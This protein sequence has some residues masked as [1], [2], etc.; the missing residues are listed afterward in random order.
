MDFFER[1]ENTLLNALSSPLTYRILELGA[2]IDRHVSKIAQ[3]HA[4]DRQELHALPTEGY[5][6]RALDFLKSR[7]ERDPDLEELEK[8]V[9]EETYLKQK[10]LES[11][12]KPTPIN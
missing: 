10:F 12:G 8:L 6:L 1:V 2:A 4:I 9:A 5:S 7:I 11:K 3:K